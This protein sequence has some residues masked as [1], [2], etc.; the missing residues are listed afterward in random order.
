MRL[1]SLSVLAS[2]LLLSACAEPANPEQQRIDV[3]AIGVG[4]QAYRCL[5]TNEIGVNRGTYELTGDLR[6]R[7]LT[8][9]AAQSGVRVFVESSNVTTY[10]SQT[11]YY[12][13]SKDDCV[14]WMEGITL[15]EFSQRLGLNPLGISPAYKEDEPAPQTP[16]PVPVPAPVQ[17]APTENAP[18]PAPT[19]APVP[20]P[21]PVK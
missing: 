4:E 5:P 14:I 10:G 3:K 20:A 13:N 21:A 7:F 11:I 19:P 18:V 17:P 12:M 6:A 2:G 1:L 9:T 16:A 8:P 15:Q